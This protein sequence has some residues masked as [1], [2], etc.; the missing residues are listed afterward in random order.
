MADW[1][2]E[3]YNRFRRYRAEPFAAIMARLEF[4]GAERIIDLG[5]GSGENTAELGRRCAG[6]AAVGLDSSPAMIDRA[7]KLREALE[8]ALRGRL[9][10]V[11]GDI[12]EFSARREYS[13]VLSN[14]AFQW[15]T[16]H[17]EVF[18]RCFQALA[19][20]GR[21]VV[22]MPANDHE[23]ALTT[24]DALAH[25]QPWR[26]RLASI[27]LPSSTVAAPAGYLRMLGEIGFAGVD[28]YYHTFHH[29]M[30]AP[31]EIAAWCRATALRPYLDPLDA[32]ARES[33]VAA[34][35]ARLE[36][37]YGTRGPLTFN[38]RRLFIWARRPAP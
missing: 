6:G 37:A 30:G 13:M 26:A 10:F 9:R 22:Q 29:P 24:I 18:A 2:P 21:L 8:P 5:C 25:E 7:C 19:P 17:R 35:T 16:G 32:V 12:R 28:C 4:G 11:L 20:G 15:L 31:A 33:F 38:F 23:T 3:L 27:R 36:Q 14:A 1:D 34:L